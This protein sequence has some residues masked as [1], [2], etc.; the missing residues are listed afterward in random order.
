MSVLQL[1]PA[2]VSGGVE[3]G[4]LEVARALIAGGHRSIVVSA[5]GP[6]VNQ[7][8]AEGS[9]HLTLPLDRKSPLALGQVLR[10]RRLLDTVRPD[11]VHARSRLPA[12]IAWLALRGMPEATRPRFVTTVHGLYSVGRYSAVMTRGDVVIAVSETARRYVLEHYPACPEARIRVIHRG[13]AA[14]EF[15]PGHRPEPAWL[16][17]W[18][19]RYPRLRDAVVITIAGRITR[20]KGHDT[21]LR[22]I[23][24]LRRDGVPAQGV[25]VGVAAR[26]RYDRELRRA[27]AQRQLDEAITFTGARDDI[28][29]VLA[30]SNLV[31]ALSVLPESFGRTAL[32]A[33]SLGVPVLGWGHGGVGEILA[34]LFPDGSVPPFDEAELVHRARML[35]SRGRGQVPGVAPF[36]LERMC[37]ETIAVYHDLVH[38][39][40]RTASS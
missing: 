24:A 29:E 17:A 14:A 10:L 13:V 21:F 38:G 11:I 32:E 34:A 12:W 31:V 23:A 33:L 36:T 20:R 15:P 22:L 19:Q 27:I 25:V 39:R 37:E 26:A 30:S 5:G 9:A 3:R 16:D 1:L 35:L 4:T 7:L 40:R 8:I 18:Y 2:L 28:R 6:L